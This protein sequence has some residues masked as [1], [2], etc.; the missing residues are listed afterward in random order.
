MAGQL[1]APREDVLLYGTLPLALL[2]PAL[3]ESPGSLVALHR[4]LAAQAVANEDG[5]REQADQSGRQLGMKPC[6][7]DLRAPA[8]HAPQG[9][10]LLSPAGAPSRGVRSP[11][12]HA[13]FAG[14]LPA[15]AVASCLQLSPQHCELL[16]STLTAVA[17]GGAPSAATSGGGAPAVSM[18][19]LLLFLLAQMY[20]RDSHKPETQDHWPDADTRLARAA[21]PGE[22]VP[23]GAPRDA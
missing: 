3:G 14:V 2:A 8:A 23:S 21:S 4:A 15:D 9:A 11:R 20:G 13:R 19:Q 6:T 1:V 7:R 12:P 18:H 5:E 17:P 10:A 22:R 16:L